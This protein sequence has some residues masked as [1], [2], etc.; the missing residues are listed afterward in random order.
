MTQSEIIA[1]FLTK[2]RNC[3]APE[4][5]H[6]LYYGLHYWDSTNYYLDGL[7]KTKRLLLQPYLERYH[8][9]VFCYELYYK[10]RVLMEHDEN[11]ERSKYLFNQ[12]H[13]FTI[14]IDKEPSRS[15]C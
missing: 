15:V 13:L 14:R 5:I 6:P 2:V 1:S 11:N 3:L 12:E 8:E 4:A 10:L 7:E 9:R